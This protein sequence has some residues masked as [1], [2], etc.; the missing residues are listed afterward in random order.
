MDHFEKN[1]D[2]P[3]IIYAI[4]GIITEIIN[5]NRQMINK[6]ITKSACLRLPGE[7]QAASIAPYPY[8]VV[9]SADEPGQQ[10]QQ[11]TSYG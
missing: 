11:P 7:E 6:W 2:S 9:A 1:I 3:A 4:K 5:N 8:R 10:L